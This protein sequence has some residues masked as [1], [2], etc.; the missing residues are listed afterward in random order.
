VHI[1]FNYANLPS[2]DA[3]EAHTRHQLDSAIGRFADRITRVEVHFADTN[4]HAKSGANDK[5]CVLEARPAGS[6]PVKVEGATDDFHTAINDAAGKL[7]R[8]LTS[9]MDR[10]V[11]RTPVSPA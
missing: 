9:R 3:L 1:Q 5:R 11:D 8:L 6:D 10:P 4:S 7:R 2:S